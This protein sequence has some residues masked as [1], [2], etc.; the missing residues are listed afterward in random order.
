MGELLRLS[1]EPQGNTSSTGIP[2]MVDPTV[3]DNISISSNT[4]QSKR[5]KISDE[6]SSLTYQEQV[7]QNPIQEKNM[8][9]IE[10]KKEMNVLDSPLVTL[11]NS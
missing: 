4:R 1:G 11:V 2:I 8:D 5:P 6:C 9:E 7:K 10:Y 3:V